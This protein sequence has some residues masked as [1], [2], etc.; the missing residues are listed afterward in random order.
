M[1]GSFKA[2]FFA[3]VVQPEGVDVIKAKVSFRQPVDVKGRPKAGV[4]S[5][6][7]YLT[8]LG[9]DLAA[10]TNWAMDPM[11]AIGGRIEYVDLV[12][13][14][15]RTVTFKDGYCVHYKENMVTSDDVAAYQFEI[16]ITAREISMDGTL[17]D[18]L[19]SNWIPGGN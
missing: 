5:D 9:N 6:I 1:A 19:W 18:N 7:I 8:L 13:G 15:M 16:G 2:K 12:G 3:K 14:T 4:R 17:H 10:L 11:K